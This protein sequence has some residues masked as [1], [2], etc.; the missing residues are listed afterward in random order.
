MEGVYASSSKERER[1]RNSTG[2]LGL[3]AVGLTLL[4]GLG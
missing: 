2:L 3:E 1:K 4:G